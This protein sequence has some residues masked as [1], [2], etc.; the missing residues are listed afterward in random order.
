MNEVLTFK[1]EMRL[2]IAQRMSDVVLVKGTFIF[3]LRDAKT[4]EIIRREIADNLVVAQGRA[5]I[6]RNIIKAATTYNGGY[7]AV[8]TSTTTVSD[9]ETSMPATI[10]GVK[11]ATK[12]IVN[13]GGVELCEWSAT[14]GT[15]EANGTIG[16]GGIVE[17]SDG[18]GLWARAV[19]SSPITK[20]SSMEL[21]VRYRIQVSSA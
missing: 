16:S 9:N 17:N 10:L 6:R 13:E 5:Y 12:S 4:K 18:T 14:F 20:D 21:T 3:E 8:S 1:D 11:V 2:G 15:T 19:L 7:I